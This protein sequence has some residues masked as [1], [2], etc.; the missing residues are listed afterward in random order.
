MSFWV[1]LESWPLRG[2][3]GHLWRGYPNT[4][5]RYLDILVFFWKCSFIVSQEATTYWYAEYARSE[6]QQCHRKPH[7]PREKQISSYRRSVHV[8]NIFPVALPTF[9]YILS[10]YTRFPTPKAKISTTDRKT[11]KSN[12]NLPIP[13]SEKAKAKG[14]IC[15]LIFVVSQNLYGIIEFGISA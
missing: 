12:G 4:F 6:V 8:V 3:G 9:S 14:A 1:L 2:F 15:I 7:A 11:I 5:L 10:A 13:H